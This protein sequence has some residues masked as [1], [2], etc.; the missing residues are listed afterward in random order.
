MSEFR[1]IPRSEAD[2]LARVG[3]IDESVFHPGMHTILAYDDKVGTTAEVVEVVPDVS[4]PRVSDDDI[5][6]ALLDWAGNSSALRVQLADGWAYSGA[7]S[8]LVDV[9]LCGTRRVLTVGFDR[10][11]RPCVVADKGVR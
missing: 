11:D 8:S 10:F 9:Q 1:R 5:D 6:A 7:P 2:R 4:L 3:A